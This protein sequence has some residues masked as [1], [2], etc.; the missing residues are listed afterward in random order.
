LRAIQGTVKVLLRAT[1]WRGCDA[2]PARARRRAL[3]REPGGREAEPAEVLHL[4]VTNGSAPFLGDGSLLTTVSP[5]GDVT[6]QPVSTML[7][8]LWARLSTP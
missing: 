5:N 1:P 4:H 3:R 7:D 6:Q 2:S 8:N